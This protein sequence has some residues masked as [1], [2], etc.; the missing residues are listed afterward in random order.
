M[1]AQLLASMGLPAHGNAF[2]ACR[3]R[4]TTP[5]IHRAPA[6]RGP[7]PSPNE[8][9][10]ISLETFDERQAKKLRAA[11]LA[12]ATR[13]NK[14]NLIINHRSQADVD[15]IGALTGRGTPNGRDL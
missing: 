15:K 7:K 1:N 8:R 4:S 14:H 5:G 9:S 6:K 2:T 3:P 13:V 11:L 12:K 10:A